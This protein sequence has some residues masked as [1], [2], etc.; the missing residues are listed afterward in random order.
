MYGLPATAC[1]GYDIHHIGVHHERGD[2]ERSL[3]KAWGEHSSKGVWMVLSSQAYPFH[4][5]D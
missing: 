2:L 5:K 4:P 1:L 3:S